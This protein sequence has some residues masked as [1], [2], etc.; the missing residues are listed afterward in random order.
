MAAPFSFLK[1]IS[2]QARYH[3]SLDQRVWRNIRPFP[4]H[5]RLAG[6]QTANKVVELILKNASI[7]VTGIWLAEDDG[8]LNP[9]NI[10]LVPGRHYTQSSR[11]SRLTPLQSPGRLDVSQLVLEDLRNRIRHTLM[12]DRLSQLV[13]AQ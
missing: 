6:C 2:K 9:A 5:E 4:A 3:V 11:F 12:T 1:A 10:H 7:A 8:V 13:S